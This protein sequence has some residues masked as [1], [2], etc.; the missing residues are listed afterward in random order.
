MDIG[1]GFGGLTIKLAKLFPNKPVAGF[2][3]RAKVCEYVRLRILALRNE[4]P[5]EFKN[6]TCL[7]YAT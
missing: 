1:C 5:G 7:R 6:A 2:E 3:I 4:H